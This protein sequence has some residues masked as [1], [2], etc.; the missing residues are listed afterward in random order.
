MSVY[1][2]FIIPI[3]LYLLLVAWL[4][5][6]WRLLSPFEV[7]DTISPVT[8]SIVIPMRNE[9]SHIGQLL[10]DIS[11]QRYPQDLI[12]VYVV[13]DHSTDHSPAIVDSFVKKYPNIRLLYLPNEEYGKKAALRHVLPYFTSTLVVTTDAD[14]RIPPYWLSNITTCYAKHHPA[15]IICPVLFTYGKSFFSRWQ[16]LELMS[17]TGSSAGAASWGHPV[18]CSGANLVMERSVMEQY[19]HIYQSPVTSGDDMMM[20]LE[21]KKDMPKRI[22]YLK[23]ASATVETTPE[24]GL[25]NFIRQRNRWTSKSSKYTDPGVIT[26]A[27]IVFLANLSIVSC[28]FTGLFN[29]KFLWLAVVLWFT[30]M[31][32]DFPFLKSLT[33]FWNRKNLMRVFFP[34]QILYPFYIVWVGTVGNLAPV[35]WKDRKSKI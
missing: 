28:I 34:A 24:A 1:F 29:I 3:V 22:I 6:G 11:S 26:I 8:V 9:A 15:M 35:K 33:H 27:L 16:A 18:M 10:A 23:S 19:A 30:K 32:I 17:L 7:T 25:K 12:R 14:C 31:L 2:Y 4:W 21:I 20:M 13:D 5:R